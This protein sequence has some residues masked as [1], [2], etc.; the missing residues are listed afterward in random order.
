MPFAPLVWLGLFC[1]LGRD[2]QLQEAELA[3]PWHRLFSVGAVG[4]QPG[5]HG[6]WLL[7]SQT[8]RQGGT[9]SLEELPLAS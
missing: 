4:R 6:T 8:G 3:G 1:V 5:L 2:E 7:G 9:L